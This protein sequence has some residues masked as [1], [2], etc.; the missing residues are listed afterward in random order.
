MSRNFLIGLCFVALGGATVGG[1][2]S[3]S[4]GSPDDDAGTDAPT[5]LDGNMPLNDS[6]APQGD[7]STADGNML[8]DGNLPVD[9]SATDTGT[10][11]NDG[12]AVDSGTTSCT[13]TAPGTLRGSAIALSSDDSTVVVV[14]RD[15]GTVTVMSV[16]YADTFPAMTVVKELTVGAEPW[17]V[18][19]DACNATAYVSLRKDQKVVAIH[20]VNTSSPT[21]GPSVAVGSEPTALALTPNN[22]KL[23]V[24]NWVD[25]TVTVVDP[26]TMTVTSSVDLNA[27]IAATGDL[28]TVASRPSLAH[29]RGIA[30]TNNGDTNDLDETA[31]VTEWFAVRTAPETAATADTNWKGLLYKI[32]LAAGGVPSTIDLPSVPNT[33]FPDA[34]G[35]QTGCFPNQIGSV[36]IDGTFAY[37]TSTCASPAGPLGVFQ[38]G[39]C[40]LDANCPGG[41]AGSCVAG[42][43]QG[44][45]T[46]DS[47]CGFGSATGAC[48][49]AAGGACAPLTANAKTTT[50]PA[51]SV[52]DLTGVAATTTTPL[53]TL[54]TTPAD[55]T[56]G[57]ASTRM[58]LLP[59]DLAFR[60]G[61][62]Y[63]AAQGADALFR[64][65]I[66]NGVIT[67][68]GSSTNNFIELRTPANVNFRLPVG[69]AASKTKGFA[70][71]AND[72]DRDVTAVDF[73]TQAVAVG[74]AGNDYR[75]TPS[76]AL[77]ASGT[78]AASQLNG[79][80]FF[81]TGL[82]RWS[83]NGAAW[84]S[85][86]GCHFDG[87]T[88]N[89]T[90]YFARGPRQTISLDGSFNKTDPTDQ[91]I[92][93]WSGIFDEIADFEGNVRT[94]SG[95]VGAI[96]S[97]ANGTCTVATQTTDCPNSQVCDPL[98][99]KCAPSVK[100]RISVVGETPQQ[101]G[102]QGSSDDA[103]NPSG[104][105][106]HAHSVIGNWGDISA[107]IQTVRSPRAPTTLVSADVTAG[108][109]LFS[110]PGQGNCVGCHGGGK[111]TIS[112]RFY[113][114]G[115]GP[116]DAFGSAAATSLS[117]TTWNAALNGF[118]LQL[119]PSATTGKQTMRSGAPP[120]FE[121]IQC[122]L[123]PVGTIIANGA[124]PTGVSPPE[125]GVIE[126]R[127]DM[128]TGAQGAGGTN[129]NDFTAGFNPPSLLGTQLGGPYF[130]AG[131]ART[132]EEA[133]STTFQG[134][135]QSPIAQVFTPSATQIQQ[136]VAF[137]LSIDGSS[138]PLAVP[139]LGNTGGDFCHYP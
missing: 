62:A 60:P 55:T 130:H 76:S 106:A 31:Y 93:N 102:L 46:V 2:G 113:T 45:C 36:T 8:V 129:A 57:T 97:I 85:C 1:C 125:V 100:D 131:N 59:S 88:D 127:Q 29:P 73:N 52:V 119:F 128:V 54:F 66:T 14:N 91:R 56:L 96:V 64:L 34:K 98:A 63:V 99:L 3:G 103:A 33:G 58:P 47:D 72:G 82:G 74:S 136:L 137:M 41:A 77:P 104:S 27:V 7:A 89:V 81:T 5:G 17:E 13:T 28:G 120:G 132:L 18:V 26:L 4:G 35:N 51:V 101:L 115:D 94:T 15:V 22:T 75:V 134:H 139:T 133:L 9:S 11:P 108:Q 23:L 6:G 79:K 10:P 123:R 78:P 24:S 87:L 105:S 43:C 48:N 118:P 83:L 71:V 20:G 135:Y 126:L 114:P 109:A 107:W 40:Q 112:K 122:V 16:S 124:V 111:W 86:A 95:G 80:R 19:L 84:G 90:W 116:N 117:N 92:Y 61:F 110:D 70:F 50:H 68:V 121:Q 38:K 30:I 53:D 44:S 25:G 37:V 65:V 32:P 67:K 138:P 69:L 39:S 49:V 12:G 21:V 42:S